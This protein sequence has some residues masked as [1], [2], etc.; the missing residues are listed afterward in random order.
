MKIWEE[1]KLTYRSVSK[2]LVP[3]CLYVVLASTSQVNTQYL[4]AH[5]LEIRCSSYL[6]DEG[7][8]RPFCVHPWRPSDIQQ[9]PE[10]YQ[11]MYLVQNN[12]QLSPPSYPEDSDDHARADPVFRKI[13]LLFYHHCGA[14]SARTSSC[15]N[16]RI[17]SFWERTGRPGFLRHGVTYKFLH[18]LIETQVRGNTVEVKKN[19]RTSHCFVI[20]IGSV[21]TRAP[22]NN[23]IPFPPFIPPD[24]ASSWRVYDAP[25]MG[26]I[27]LYF[28]VVRPRSVWGVLLL[29]TP[30]QR[31]L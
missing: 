17:L 27:S 2:M 30:Y 13:L 5:Q 12:I 24:G 14:R 15:K 10:T 21:L 26:A 18:H 20:I 4:G 25:F 22:F 31:D 1:D 6:F 3:P 7:A 23:H 8:N 29:G 9:P 11:H 19:E 28:S 16:N